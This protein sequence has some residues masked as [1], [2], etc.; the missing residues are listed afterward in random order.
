MDDQKLNSFADC[1]LRFHWT[2]MELVLRPWRDNPVPRLSSFHTMTALVPSTSYSPC[3][4]SYEICIPSPAI[5]QLTAA[6]PGGVRSRRTR[7]GWM[8]TISI[9]L[10]FQAQHRRCSHPISIGH[11]RDRNDS[12]LP[13]PIHAD[14]YAS[15]AID[16]NFRHASREP[17]RTGPLA[18]ECHLRTLYYLARTFNPEVRSLSSE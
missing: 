4:P 1:G 11:A 13:W 5:A 9:L 14:S 6:L 3:G 16:L 12:P 10:L 18:E 7:P 17:P 15:S 2:L 8:C